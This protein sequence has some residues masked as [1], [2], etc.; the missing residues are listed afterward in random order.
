MFMNF[1]NSVTHV[2]PK[3]IINQFL[4]H[5]VMR[6]ILFHNKARSLVVPLAFQDNIV[7]YILH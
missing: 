7:H 3:H 1:T 5:H 4:Y 2:H 6:I